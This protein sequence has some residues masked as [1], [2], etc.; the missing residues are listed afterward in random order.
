MT[1]IDRPQ[2]LAQLLAMAETMGI[3]VDDL[4]AASSSRP[5]EESKSVIDFLPAVEA[6]TTD[7]AKL[8]YRPYWRLLVAQLGDRPVSSVKA[9]DLQA[10]ALEA[11]RRAKHRSNT[12]EAAPRP[13]RTV[14]VPCVPSSVWRSK[15]A[16][17]R[18]A[19]PTR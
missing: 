2:M 10:L 3:T 11:Q 13:E 4:A 9:T 12:P 14:S 19:L 5:S 16:S 6:A 1:S 7:G 8:T 17:S 18:R 15:T